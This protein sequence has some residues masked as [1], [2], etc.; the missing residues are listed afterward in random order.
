M[1]LRSGLR[2]SSAY[3]VQSLSGSGHFLLLVM[4]RIWN[5][6]PWLHRFGSFHAVIHCRHFFA[7]NWRPCFDSPIS[8]YI[9]SQWLIN[10]FF[11]SGHFKNLQCNYNVKLC[12][13]VGLPVNASTWNDDEYF[14]VFTQQ[15]IT[16]MSK[17]N[18]TLPRVWRQQSIF[19][20]FCCRRWCALVVT[21]SS[22]N[23]NRIK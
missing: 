22:R 9:A 11:Y 17:F 23:T 16:V 12:R 6:L 7:V 3:R 15:L 20:W 13:T 18:E 5:S 4:H 14:S 8:I 2:S 19:R 21:L 1:P 10:K